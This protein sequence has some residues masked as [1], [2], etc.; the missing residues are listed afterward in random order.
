MAVE[1]RTTTVGEGI[2]SIVNYRIS[3]G[4]IFAGT[5]V[6]LVVQ[7]GLSL[8]GMGIRAIQ[9]AAG[10]IGAIAGVWL[11]LSSIISLFVG[12]WVATRMSG[13]LL[14]VEGIL[15]GLV[16][17]G[18]STLVTFYLMTSAFGSLISSAAGA[19]GMGFTA[20]RMPTGPEVTGA[21]SEVARTLPNAALWG[22]IGLLLGAIGAAFGG[23]AGRPTHLMKA[24]GR[25]EK[26][27]AERFRKAV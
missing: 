4:A 18:L 22:F 26:E 24:A 14:P 2:E 16:I 17:W 21:I 8:L 11:L 23:W 6:A 9:P 19:L 15:H 13:V 3:W 20:M 7:V 10:G 1:Y 12:G 25:E 5:V 27:A